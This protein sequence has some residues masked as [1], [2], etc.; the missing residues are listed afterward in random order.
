MNFLMIL[1][2]LI[3]P[4]LYT[5]IGGI[6]VAIIVPLILILILVTQKKWEI[7]N[8]KIF[9]IQI[10]MLI[11][12]VSYALL[13]EYYDNLFA[14]L[15]FFILSIVLSL[16]EI[17]DDELTR[18]MKIYVFMGIFSAVG[19]IIQYFAYSMFGLTFGTVILFNNRTAFSFLWLDFSFFSLYLASLVPLIFFVFKKNYIKLLF[20]LIVLIASFITTARTGIFSFFLFFM[21]YVL[22][23]AY[24]IFLTA[25]LSVNNAKIIFSILLISPLVLLC[26][27]Y[28]QSLSNR[29]ITASDSG[30]TEGYLSAINYVEN[31]LF[32]GYMFDSDHYF[33][34]INVLPHN[35]I[36]YILT[37]GGV[38][39]LFLF[40]I[41][42]ILIFFY[43]KNKFILSSIL[44]SL[45]GTMFIPSF[46]SMYYLGFLISASLAYYN[47]DTTRSN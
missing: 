5:S 38:V 36:L 43:S 41:F 30:R 9:I 7:K 13:T 27:P 46:Y 10:F 11:L 31:N 8:K 37:M 39:F 44:I 35:S 18:L 14:F 33:N 29:E 24:R 16:K 40:C 32:F 4:F 12:M 23:H 28:I 25:R 17:N 1:I 3:I 19:L 45:I 47:L 22:Y 6:R 20:S 2:P 42:L 21:F 26:I 34:N 15:I